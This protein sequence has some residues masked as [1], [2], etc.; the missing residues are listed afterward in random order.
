LAKVKKTPGR[1]S[2]GK[3]ASAR[4]S[5]APARKTASS[6][7]SRGSDKPAKSI[8]ADGAPLARS[9][10]PPPKRRSMRP[11]PVDVTSHVVPGR[12]FVQSS[13]ALLAQPRSPKASIRTPAGAEELKQKIA[14]LSRI[15]TQL[16]N[17]KRT[18]GQSFYEV[19][20][21]LRSIETDRLYEVKGYVAFDAFVERE[22][23]IGKH[24]AVKLSRVPT[25][26]IRDAAREIG[27]DRVLAAID[28]LYDSE[29]GVT[30][31][32]AAGVRAPVPVPKPQ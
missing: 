29:E 4:S 5:V 30:T 15:T 22:V 27:V 6:V 10:K 12:K 11:G 7:S 14:A 20:E 8:R 21:L 19:G 32:T 13:G 31:G 26:F 23:G 24:T 9:S 25:T 1:K 3:R 17:L 2:S 18:M 28:V 16:K